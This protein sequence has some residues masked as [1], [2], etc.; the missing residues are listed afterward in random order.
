MHL[1]RDRI[2]AIISTYVA[3]SIYYLQSSL[4]N[5]PMLESSV[6]KYMMSEVGLNDSKINADLLTL[7]ARAITPNVQEMCKQF[8]NMLDATICDLKEYVNR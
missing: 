8:N 6:M 5:L 2:E 7:K 1:F 4:S 3:G